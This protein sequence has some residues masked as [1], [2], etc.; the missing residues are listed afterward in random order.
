MAVSRSDVEHIAAL[1]RLDIPSERVTPLLAELNGILGHM[2]VLSS[3]NTDGVEDV[4]GVGA[5]GMPLRADAGPAIPLVRP[6]VD[7][8]PETKGGFILVPRL[9]THESL[10]ES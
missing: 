1:A 8:A 2:E 6:L 7:F 4:A 9:S 10:G 3:V 5:E